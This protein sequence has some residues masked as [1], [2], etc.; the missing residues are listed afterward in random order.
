MHEIG[1]R[2]LIPGAETT[3]GALAFY[4]SQLHAM[5]VNQYAMTDDVA[6]QRGQSR[7]REDIAPEFKGKPLQEILKAYNHL[8]LKLKIPA[9][10]ETL[11][12]VDVHLQSLKESS[13]AKDNKAYSALSRLSVQ[14]GMFQALSE[15]E[16]IKTVNSLNLADPVINHELQHGKDDS[17]KNMVENGTMA[18]TPRQVVVFRLA[19][20][21][22]G[23]AA[24]G[25]LNKFPGHYQSYLKKTCRILFKA[26]ACFQ[27]K[28]IR[29]FTLC[30]P[31]KVTIP[32]R[33]YLCRR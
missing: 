16:K 26:L 9:D 17:L 25:E 33:K 3:P 19:H 20:E 29:C 2:D 10:A 18:L 4:N 5:V 8:S 14:T 31:K 12:E 21:M 1:L 27:A 32:V 22:K 11:A 6:L 28:L 23:W 7:S 30:R 13:A 15:L 24:A